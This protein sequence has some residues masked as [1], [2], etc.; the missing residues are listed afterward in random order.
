MI[1]FTGGYTSLYT[2][3]FL[4]ANFHFVWLRCRYKVHVR[5]PLLNV[6]RK[7]WKI[8]TSQFDESI[9]MLYR[10]SSPQWDFHWSL[11]SYFRYTALYTSTQRLCNESMSIKNSKLGHVS[12]RRVFLKN[13]TWPKTVIL[14]WISDIFLRT[15]MK[16]KIFRRVPILKFSWTRFA[17]PDIEAWTEVTIFL[18]RRKEGKKGAE[19]K[20]E[21]KG[22]RLLKVIQ[23][24]LIFSNNGPIWM[25]LKNQFSLRIFVFTEYN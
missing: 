13:K 22:G 21:H 24:P 15:C 11:L 2:A 3:N 1:G 10:Y 16:M 9:Y 5:F 18:E 23:I 4:L 8:T 25:I 20:K 19:R 12:V 14:L 7:G 17:F 6:F